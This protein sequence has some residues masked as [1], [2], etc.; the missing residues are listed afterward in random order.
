MN[1]SDVDSLKC[2]QH[3]QKERK[4]ENW[5]LSHKYTDQTLGRPRCIFG[6]LVQPGDRNVLKMHFFSAVVSIYVSSYVSLR[7]R[8]KPFLAVVAKSLIIRISPWRQC[9]RK[10]F[11]RCSQSWKKALSSNNL[12][13]FVCIK[14]GGECSCLPAFGLFVSALHIY[15]TYILQVIACW[16]CSTPWAASH[17]TPACLPSCAKDFTFHFCW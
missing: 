11:W 2:C 13:L 14:M 12:V 10:G 1:I 5:H 4:C 3:H 7:H 15:P 6:P 9:W 17:P 16:P 8:W